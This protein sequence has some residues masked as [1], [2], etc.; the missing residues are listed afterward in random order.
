VQA[1]WLAYPGTTGLD[2]ID[3]RLTDPYLDPPGLF[4]DCYCERSI[5]MADT[6]W[7][8]PSLGDEPDVSPLPCLENGIITFGCMNNFC[9][10]NDAVLSL[11]ARVLSAVARSRLILLVPQG[12]ARQRVLDRMNSAGIDSSRIDMVGGQLHFDYLRTFQRI[13]IALDTFPYNGHT[14]SLD[15]FFMGVPVITLVGKTIVGRAGLSQLTN[16]RLA[17]LIAQTPEQYIQI[18]SNLAADRPRL[19]ELRKTLRQRMQDS[20]LMD[21]Q[22]FTRSLEDAFR[23]MWRAWCRK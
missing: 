22:R 3:Y 6:F 8:Y 23:T 1:T 9:K 21:G 18:A 13:D 2:A 10:V 7:C 19:A 20:P 4:D 14:T 16:L 12:C 15:S 5:R 11:W 17:E